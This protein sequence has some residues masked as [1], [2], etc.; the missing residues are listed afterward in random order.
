MSRLYSLPAALSL[1]ALGLLPACESMPQDSALTEELPLTAFSEC[2]ITADLQLLDRAVTSVETSRTVDSELVYADIDLGNGTE[3][4]MVAELGDD[5]SAQV[6]ILEDGVGVYWLEV[7]DEIFLVRSV[8]EGADKGERLTFHQG[9]LL[10]W[11]QAQEDVT[12]DWEIYGSRFNSHPMHRL[13]LNTLDL[14]SQADLRLVRVASRIYANRIA[15][16]PNAPTECDAWRADPWSELHDSATTATQGAAGPPAGGTPV[17]GAI[18]GPGFAKEHCPLPKGPTAQDTVAKSKK[19]KGLEVTLKQTYWGFLAVDMTMSA[20]DVSINADCPPNGDCLRARSNGKKGKTLGLDD[21]DPN[22]P[23]FMLS[24]LPHV[25]SED[26]DDED[27]YINT[28]FNACGSVG[29][30]ASDGAGNDHAN[31]YKM[32]GDVQ[33]GGM[34]LVQYSESWADSEGNGKGGF[35]YAAFSSSVGLERDAEDDG[36]D[37]GSGVQIETQLDTWEAYAD[38][39]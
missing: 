28:W 14:H 39:L 24:G 15:A 35:S 26:N 22:K 6:E 36:D 18:P 19:T 8:N 3:L 38:L 12:A 21:V 13:V 33:F 32:T 1:A 5:G 11:L 2:E 34:P 4:S 23:G 37:Y 10:D 27:Y 7:T 20:G 9:G 17:P 25:N 30:G 16:D 29:T 31:G